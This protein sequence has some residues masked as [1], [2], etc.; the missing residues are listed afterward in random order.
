M[1]RPKW[2]ILK[3]AI[4]KEVWDEAAQW[5]VQNTAEVYWETFNLNAT[6]LEGWWVPCGRSGAVQGTAQARKVWPVLAIKKS[7]RGHF[8]PVAKTFAGFIDPDEKI[9]WISTAHWDQ[10]TGDD[11][12]ARCNDAADRIKRAAR[13]RLGYR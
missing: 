12:L 7:H 6:T 13:R 5:H 8:Y 9:A 3:K 4:T 11:T 10:A 2:T 1:I